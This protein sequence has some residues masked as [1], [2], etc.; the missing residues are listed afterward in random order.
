MFPGIKIDE[1]EN[2]LKIKIL[3]RINPDKLDSF[4]NMKR[5]RK[6]NQKNETLN[7]LS[8]F[9]YYYLLY[10]HPIHDYKDKL[11]FVTKED[12]IV[13]IKKKINP[14]LGEGL[15]IIIAPENFSKLVV[16]NHD[17]DMYLVIK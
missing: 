16:C 6:I 15:D 1:N 12:L 4:E 11:F 13:F 17:G 7:Y 3:S 2:A 5:W 10:K 9:Q 14:D 8:D